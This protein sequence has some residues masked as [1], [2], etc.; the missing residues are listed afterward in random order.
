MRRPMHSK[1]AILWIVAL[2]FVV[3]AAYAETNQQ[4]AQ[5][6]A[7]ASRTQFRKAFVVDDRLSALRRY[8]DVKSP[9]VRRLHIGRP[10]F[11]I[12]RKM[13]GAADARFYYVAVTRRTRGG[14]PEAALAVLGRAGEDARLMKLIE[15][16]TDGIDRIALCRL[17][18]EH[19]NRAA[20]ARRALLAIGEE[21]ERAAATLTRNAR[22]RLRDLDEENGN[23]SLRDY[24]LNDTGLDR[25]SRLYVTFDLKGSTSEYRYD[26]KAY[27][28]IVRRYPDSEEARIARSRID[29]SGQRLANQK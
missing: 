4:S 3:P 22:K 16:A 15:K 6:P 19:F 17:L 1:K 10:V 5:Q 18:L 11:I 9:V 26:G 28:E 23:A 7:Q 27:R 12:D 8:P 20:L 14:I 24:Y 29:L 2:L 25:Y 13:S 21:A